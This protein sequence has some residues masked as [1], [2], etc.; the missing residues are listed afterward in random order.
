MLA[1]QAYHIITGELLDTNVII[2][3][4]FAKKTDSIYLSL[5]YG[6]AGMIRISNHY[7]NKYQHKYNLI[8]DRHKPMACTNDLLY[9]CEDEIYDMIERIKE[10]RQ[11]M[12]ENDED[13]YN[14][15]VDTN[16]NIARISALGFWTYA[17]RVN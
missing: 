11:Q 4:Y 6:A 12:I 13:T 2:H 10:N 3:H 8:V 17:R 15:L 5:D 14:K 16:I 1:Q 7:S 9:F